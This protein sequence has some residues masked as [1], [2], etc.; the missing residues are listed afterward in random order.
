[1]MT[2]HV[3]PMPTPTP[4]PSDLAG[5]RPFL[6]RL[7]L[8]Q[9]GNDA[10]ADDAVQETLLAAAT[11]MGNYAGSVPLRAWLVGI[12]RHKIVDAI[13]V[14]SRFVM[15]DCEG[16]GEAIDQE[17]EVSRMFDESGTWRPESLGHAEAPE[18]LADRNQLLGLVE[19]CMQ[20]LPPESAKVF[21]MRE[22]LGM[23]TA[24]IAECTHLSPGNLRVRLHRAR[25]RLRECV[26]R[27]WGELR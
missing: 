2:S 12:L 3:S 16:D 24:E 8:L 14:R 9:L 13:R 1:M 21:L 17:A 5:H 11:G 6:R 19:L 26:V 20:A 23:A 4:W 15:F 22:Y 7:A 27:G 10:D 18:A 25:M